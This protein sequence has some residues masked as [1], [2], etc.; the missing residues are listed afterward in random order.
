MWKPTRRG[1][2]AVLAL[3]FMVVILGM[4][5]FVVDVGYLALTRTRLQAAA[6]AGALAGAATINLPRAE[7]EAEAKSIASQNM[8]GQP[9]LNS[10]DIEYGVWDAGAYTFA[11]SSSAANAVRVTVRTSENN[12]GATPLFFARIFGLTSVDQSAT[13]IATVNP[14][15]ICF[16]VDLSASMNYDTRPD[17]ADSSAANA[18]IQ[19]VYG[20]FGFGTYPGTSQY[21][22]YPLT[23]QT[24]GSDWLT[25]LKS[26]LTSSTF[27]GTIYFTGTYKSRRYYD[28]DG[29]TVL[30]DATRTQR[31]YAWVMDV[32]IGQQLMPAATPK[33]NSTNSTSYNYW[34]SYIDDPDSASEG[35]KNFY[36]RLGYASYVQFM[37]YHGRDGKPDDVNRTPMSIDNPLCPYHSESTDG[38]TFTF[39]P[40]EQPTHAARR[41]IIAALQVVKERNANISDMNQKDWVSIVVYD[42]NS[43]NSITVSQALT[44]DY[45]STMQ[46]ATKL[47]ACGS[48]PA[49]TCTEGGLVAAYNHIKPQ[50][51]G[52]KGREHV[53]KVVVLLT[54]GAP[55][56]RQSSNTT[57]NSYKTANPSSY[58]LPSCSSESDYCKQA[59]LM[60]AS[61][62]QGKNWYLYPV[63]LGLDVATDFMDRMAL[64][65]TTADKDGKSFSSTDPSSHEA[66]L[67]KIFE[68]IITRPK[69]RLVQ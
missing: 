35:S 16:V 7:M 61:T 41:A 43:T 22:G 47:Q 32:Q 39:P 60:E 52:G 23:G 19:K 62:M 14:R 42:K 45:S 69:L 28:S 51:Q 9:V 8:S 37:M 3:V 13:A 48:G 40:Q 67:K 11:P 34:K 64:M 6:D 20:D 66:T 24:S 44:D 56:L 25:P 15:D 21:A 63:G 49:C 38:G 54:D 30:S 12:G 55:N 1:A 26:A 46:I 4:V 53:N 59:S 27:K 58:W 29:K 18:L 50:S 10:S 17:R 65:S 33:P 57:I 31:A 68:T 2:I 36:T 5:A